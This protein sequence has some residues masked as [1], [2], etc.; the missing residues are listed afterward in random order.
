MAMVM[1]R[2]LNE[3]VGFIASYLRY[4]SK[5]PPIASTKLSARI[6][7][8]FPSISVTTGVLSVTGKYSR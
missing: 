5:L 7:G 3:Q 4:S 2:S 6:S 8:V 1:P